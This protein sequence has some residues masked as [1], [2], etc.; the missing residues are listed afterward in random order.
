MVGEATPVP[1]YELDGVKVVTPQDDN[2]VRQ[3]PFDYF[4]WADVIVTQLTCAY[5]GGII[6]AGMRKPVVVYMHNDHPRMVK[7]LDRYGWAGWYNTEWV[8]QKCQDQGVW[9]PGPTLHPIVDPALYATKRTR[10]AKYVTLVNL[11]NGENGTYDKG[12]RTFFELAK[13]NPEIP[14]L[15][16]RGAYGEQAYEDLPNVTYLDHQADMTEVY[17]QTK[18]LLVPSKYESY[19]RVA[20]EA[21]ASGIPSICSMTTGLAEAMDT[22]ALYAEYGDHETWNAQL[23][24][25]LGCCY[26]EMSTAAK[27]RSEFLWK[28]SQEE[29]EELSLM[30]EIIAAGDF[31]E[32]YDYLSV[33]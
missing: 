20:V 19:G 8:R 22:A 18:V 31:H 7:T 16:V 2:E 26:S 29:L 6:A 27:Q 32:Y 33:R 15:G 21:A 4:A 17:K 28:Q 11:S 1:S 5:R 30:F 10:A 13:R 24:D 12:Y 3:Q 23:Q 25:L 14:F 9:T